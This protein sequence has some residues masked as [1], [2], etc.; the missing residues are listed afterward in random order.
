MFNL[1]S[2][3]EPRNIE[4]FTSISGILLFL[5]PEDLA[6]DTEH[7]VLSLG[8]TYVANCEKLIMVLPSWSVKFC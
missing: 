2:Y 4:P 7:T 5:T 3:Q 1:I 6:R 8:L